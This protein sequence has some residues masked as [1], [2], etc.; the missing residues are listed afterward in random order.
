M[1]ADEAKLAHPDGLIAMDDTDETG[2]MS[3]CYY[4]TP[5]EGNFDLGYMVVDGTVQRI[6]V[7]VP[8]LTFK[9]GAGVGM[10]ADDVKALYPDA[11]VQPDKYAPELEN[12]STKLSGGAKAVF[13]TGDDG[14][15]SAYRVGM[16]PPV[17]YVEGCS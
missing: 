2:A 1:T 13:E 8:G 16:A 17:D 5:E 6:D 4:M 9:N 7:R 14:I 11:A 15:V 3:A 10:S 12:I